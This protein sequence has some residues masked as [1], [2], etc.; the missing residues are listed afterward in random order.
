MTDFHPNQIPACPCGGPGPQDHLCCEVV[1]ADL[2]KTQAELAAAHEAL[3]LQREMLVR[4]MSERDEAKSEAR[5]YADKATQ[6]DKVIVAMG[7]IPTVSGWLYRAALSP[8]P[9]AAPEEKP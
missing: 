8:S 2:M 3:A 9:S 6:A 1:A 4:T 7:G 5:M